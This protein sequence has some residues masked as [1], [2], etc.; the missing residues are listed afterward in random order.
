MNKTKNRYPRIETSFEYSFFISIVLTMVITSKNNNYTFENFIIYVGVLITLILLICP[1]I[2][3]LRI[4]LW[5][6]SKN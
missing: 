2:H 3:I 4:G 1:I 5:K 6:I